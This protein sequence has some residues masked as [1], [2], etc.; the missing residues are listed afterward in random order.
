M[1]HDDLHTT[2]FAAKQKVWEMFYHEQQL[3]SSHLA[4]MTSTCSVS[5]Q[6]RTWR[7][8]SDSEP[9]RSTRSDERRTKLLSSPGE[10][11]YLIL[12]AVHQRKD[13]SAFSFDVDDL[14][15]VCIRSFKTLNSEESR[16]TF[17][18]LGRGWDCIIASFPE[19]SSA[20]ADPAFVP[21]LNSPPRNDDR[22]FRVWFVSFS[23]CSLITR[24]VLRAMRVTLVAERNVNQIGVNK[25]EREKDISWESYMGSLERVV[26]QIEVNK[27]GTE[28]DISQESYIGSWER[29][30]Y[31]GEWMNK[32]EGTWNSKTHQEDASSMT[33]FEVKSLIAS[34]SS[35][36]HPFKV[37]SH[38]RSQSSQYPGVQ[39][40]EQDAGLKSGGLSSLNTWVRSAST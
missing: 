19:S 7:T 18:W 40:A 35:V 36:R 1:H 34:S 27:Y 32:W 23:F 38:R 37:S 17:P 6:A 5:R 3:Q 15:L 33:I 30:S 25:Y 20:L 9:R 28:K 21:F 8:V 22:N 39:V 4:I 14:L 10:L 2:S 26:N 11:C 13:F 24:C 16:R 12:Q 29:E 31:Q